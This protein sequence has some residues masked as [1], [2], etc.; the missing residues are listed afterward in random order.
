MS[1]FTRIRS[2][3]VHHV[4]S[5]VRGCL[6]V[7]E[8][9]QPGPR[10]PIYRV[11]GGSWPRPRWSRVVVRCWVRLLASHSKRKP[12]PSGGGAA[13]QP[14][15]HSWCQVP[16]EPR[17]S[18]HAPWRSR[19]ESCSWARLLGPSLQGA[20]QRPLCLTTQRRVGAA[21]S[22]PA[23]WPLGSGLGGAPEGGAPRGGQAWGPPDPGP[24][25][26]LSSRSVC[27]SFFISTSG[28]CVVVKLWYRGWWA[29][30]PFLQQEMRLCDH[31][32]VR[33]G[34]CWGKPWAPS[35]SLLTYAC[36]SLDLILLH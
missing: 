10:V 5:S 11:G 28:L 16:R 14:A 18:E 19:D 35:S 6:G 26:L 13:R 17:A 4:G 29:L 33:S 7:D 25:C 24:C 22:L 3:S 36:C 32:G 15:A 2:V 34:I 31:R 30:A 20:G 9:P 27:G 1:E 12:S 21:A 23:L 8:E